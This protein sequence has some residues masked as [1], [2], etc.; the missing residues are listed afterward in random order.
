MAVLAMVVVVAAVASMVVALATV[1]PKHQ[2]G[3]RAR[4]HLIL[5]QQKGE[6]LLGMRPPGHPI[7]TPRMGA[8]RPHGM[9]RRVP[10]IPMPQTADGRPLGTHHHALRTHTQVAVPV[11]RL[12]LGA[13]RPLSRPVPGV[14]VLVQA[15]VARHR[16]GIKLMQVIPFWNYRIDADNNYVYRTHQRQLRVCLRPQQRPHPRHHGSLVHLG[17]ARLL[18]QLAGGII[19]PAQRR[20]RLE[21]PLQGHLRWRRTITMVAPNLV[22]ICLFPTASF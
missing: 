5:T 6:H 3:E 1:L 8:K 12:A 21:P 18:Q 15:G 19:M 9:H 13:G 16:S 22:S 4:E 11:E 20:L 7:H 2:L 17:A 14:I 10:P